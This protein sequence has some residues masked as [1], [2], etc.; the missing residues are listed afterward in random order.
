MTSSSGIVGSTKTPSPISITGVSVSSDSSDSGNSGSEG[1]CTSSSRG[2]G[3]GVLSVL[4][5]NQ[6]G[7]AVGMS[8]SGICA[9][10]SG[11]VAS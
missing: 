8:I 2:S 5:L 6:A 10:Y 7:S 3:S 9:G 4:V 1:C 11:S